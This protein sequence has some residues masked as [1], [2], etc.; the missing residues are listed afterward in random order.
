MNGKPRIKEMRDG[1]LYINCSKCGGMFPDSTFSHRV[2]RNGQIWASGYCKQCTNARN[3]ERSI[4]K[5]AQ[6]RGVAASKIIA[7]RHER[8]LRSKMR[9]EARQHKKELVQ[10]PSNNRANI[11]ID[12]QNACGG[13][14][15][16][17][18]ETWKK[19]KPILFQPVDGWTAEKIYRVDQNGYVMETYAI[20]ACP[21]F[22]PD[23]P[24]KTQDIV[25][26]K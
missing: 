12:C 26:G 15:W 20:T 23:E 10:L 25:D 8:E 21:E 24:R 4:M 6:E 17:R 5:A 11:C 18:C 1:I 16:T 2:G 19:G 13:C 9:K 14:S 22:V 3:K 7:E